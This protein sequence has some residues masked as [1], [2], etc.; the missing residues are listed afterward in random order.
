MKGMKGRVPEYEVE[1]AWNSQL[2]RSEYV[3]G[4]E[5]IGNSVQIVKALKEYGVSEADKDLAREELAGMLKVK[6]LCEDKRGGIKAGDVDGKQ[7]R[8]SYEYN[9]RTVPLCQFSLEVMEGLGVLA[10]QHKDKKAG[11]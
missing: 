5:V 11:F 10:V 8:G 7:V 3:A 1:S 9:L 4:G 2:G 6:G